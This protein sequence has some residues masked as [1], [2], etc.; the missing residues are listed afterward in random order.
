MRLVVRSVTAVH[1]RRE[2]LE[3]AAGPDDGQRTGRVRPAVVE[4]LVGA[5]PVLQEVV[6]ERDARVLPV[7][8][9]L[10]TLLLERVEVV[11]AVDRLGVER[12]LPGDQGLAA[13]VEVVAHRQLDV[14]RELGGGPTGLALLADDDVVTGL[15]HDRVVVREHAEVVR[16]GA[17]VGVDVVHVDAAT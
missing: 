1:L 9:A 8:L 11:D 15:P 7:R 13:L 5:Q 16:G 2:P 10:V 14:E 12:V 17:V 4:V 3:G 6:P